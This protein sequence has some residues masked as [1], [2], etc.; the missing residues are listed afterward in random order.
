MSRPASD[1]TSDP[2]GKPL[3]K[4]ML[5][6]KKLSNST[7]EPKSDP[8]GALTSEAA[9]KPSANGIDKRSDEGCGGEPSDK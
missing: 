6:E 5:S 3:V 4:P 8:M 2:S 1:P 7:T 9:E